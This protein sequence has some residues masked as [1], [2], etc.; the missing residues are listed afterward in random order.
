MPKKVD[1]VDR[2]KS[3]GQT[4]TTMVGVF[5]ILGF[6]V[7]KG[8]AEDK[9]DLQIEAKIAP[10]IKK[11][12]AHSKDIKHIKF[13]VTQLLYLAKKTAG[14]KAVREMEEETKIFAPE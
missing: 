13:N 14:K 9:I 2:V 4:F 12:E 7:W 5:T 11:V 6:L 3:V 10:I 8:Y 1:M